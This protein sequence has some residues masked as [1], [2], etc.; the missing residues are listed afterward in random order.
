MKQTT[1]KNW[2]FIIVAFV[3]LL[4]ALQYFT[5]TV[6]S[7]GL[8]NVKDPPDA[9]FNWDAWLTGEYQQQKLAYMS[10][11]FGFRPDL[12]R[13]NNQLDY[14]A[15]SKIHVNR[16][17]CGKKQHLFDSLVAE[18]YFGEDFLGDEV[19]TTQFLKLKRIEDTMKKLG[20]T[21]VFTYG[22]SKAYYYPELLPPVLTPRH[23]R[24]VSNYRSMTRIGD[25]LKIHQ[26]DFARWLGVISDTDKT[27]L[28]GRRGLHW[29][30]YAAL[31]AADSLIKYIERDRGITM[32]H[33]RITAVHHSDSTRDHDDDLSSWGNLIFPLK[34]EV[35]AYADYEYISNDSCTKPK[36]VY[37]GDSYIR[38]WY[39]DGLMKNINSDWEY[40]FYFNEI[41]N[42]KTLSGEE[43]LHYVKDYDWI[44]A[45]L[46]A[47]CTVVMLTTFNLNFIR[48]PA[49]YI[50]GL[51][52]HFYPGGK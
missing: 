44:N 13:L 42:P 5:N 36:M 24:G 25:S 46:K 15:F 30:T 6:V 14:W 8:D 10:S 37:I 39:H 16:I 40:W 43:K 17:F 21:I 2:L 49:F 27:S 45:I 52:D 41:W 48:L 32:P 1:A 31:L 38:Y 18:E 19:I 28:I 33:I 11:A 23:P 22:P 4:P 34:K 51:Y 20:K 12:V 47:D 9:T 35:E 50:D 7:K 3:M 29:T 26:I